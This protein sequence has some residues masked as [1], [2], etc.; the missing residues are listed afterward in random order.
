[1][2]RVSQ[3]SRQQGQNLDL[4]CLALFP[5]GLGTTGKLGEVYSGDEKLGVLRMWLWKVS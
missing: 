2:N 1:M 4:S 5:L 3:L